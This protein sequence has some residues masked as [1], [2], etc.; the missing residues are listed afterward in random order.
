MVI[1]N[2]QTH[3]LVRL[4]LRAWE[5]IAGADGTRDL[6]ALLL[7][8]ARIG[9]YR[10]ASEVLTLL[11]QLHDLDLLADGLEPPKA[12]EG[13]VIPDERPIVAL[14]GFVIS[15]DLGG[16]CCGQY[17]SIGFEPHAVVRARALL[18][19][20]L[21]AGA[22]PDRVFLPLAGA[23]GSGGSSAAP[24]IDGRCA[25]LGVGTV[26]NAC[27]IHAKGGL[28]AKPLG[29]RIYPTTLVDDGREIRASVKIE[30]GCVLRSL[31]MPNGSPIVP[32][33]ARTRGE[34]D[35]GIEIR[36]LPP[37][38]VVS[39]Q[40]MP[41]ATESLSAWSR[42]VAAAKVADAL[43]ATWAL[44]DA[45]ENDGLA[46]HV[47]VAAME[48]TVRPPLDELRVRLGAL[49]TRA[50]AGATSASEWRSEGDWTRTAR[51][52]V[53]AALEALA[54]SPTTLEAALAPTEP[55]VA[56]EE[57]FYLR[58]SIFGHHLIADLPLCEA[59]RD[60]TMRL[61]VARALPN[62][63]GG[64]QAIAM[65]EAVFRTASLSR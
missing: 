30:C 61:L 57:A 7:A 19:D 50:R 18:P 46:L 2:A 21:E 64:P 3:R 55:S 44:A 25:Y 40:S 6:D 36:A 48:S 8:A 23:V 27:G 29:C 51:G 33:N 31:E 20:V 22:R 58:A 52:S 62:F 5:L 65:A 35:R 26:E 56:R 41:V 53:A 9:A 11:R 39:G 59:L 1:H 43:A 54:R 10:R 63:G 4:D 14:D 47:S 60:R 17:P 38:V 24:M 16:R 42:E 13:N 32:G 45:V 28:D 37:I 34:L 49:A 12:P 15:C